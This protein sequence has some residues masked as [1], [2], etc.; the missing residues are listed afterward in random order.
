MPNFYRSS[1]E[2]MIAGVCVGIARQYDGGAL[3]SGMTGMA[4]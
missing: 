2:Q 3:R 4:C 1:D